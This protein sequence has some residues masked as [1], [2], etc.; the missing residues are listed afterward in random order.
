MYGLL[1]FGYEAKK[2]T[3]GTTV[4]KVTSTAGKEGGRAANRLGFRGV[5]DI[6]GGLTTSF[7][8]ETGLAAEGSTPMNLTRQANLGVSGGFGA[9]RIGTFSNTF[10]SMGG[11]HSTTHSGKFIMSSGRSQNAISYATPSFNGLVIGV[12]TTSEKT[13]VD[14]TT[15]ATAKTSGTQISA[16]Y[17][18]GPL[19][20]LLANNSAT[21]GAE[22]KFAGQTVNPG[23]KLKETAAKVTY[24]MGV[25]VP[26]VTIAK[27]NLK[28]TVGSASAKLGVSGN[29]IGATFPMGAITP[30]IAIAS[31]NYKLDGGKI[32]KYAGNSVGI[33]YA[34]SKRTMAYAILSSSKT[35]NAA[36]ATTEKVSQT[37]VGIRHSF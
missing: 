5:E 21:A 10:D 6:G 27:G 15:A 11:A 7:Q 25:A 29:E 28:G 3:A 36:G 22:V 23:L 32:G 34:L 24:N 13:T 12:G 37:N 18:A 16:S 35:K 31:A 4:T 30:F 9:V 19:T 14:G 20:V 26:Y 1:D 33:D 8:F 2:T 17:N